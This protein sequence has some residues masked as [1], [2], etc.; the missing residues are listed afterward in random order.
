MYLVLGNLCVEAGE[1]EGESQ[2]P[3]GRRAPFGAPSLAPEITTSA[4]TQSETLTRPTQS[5]TPQS[6]V[7][8]FLP[9]WDKKSSLLIEILLS[10]QS[11]LF[12]GFQISVHLLFLRQT[13]GYTRGGS[14]SSGL[15]LAVFLG[16]LS[17]EPLAR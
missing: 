1:R 9:T 3:A 13:S 16:S 5:G 12:P 6:P 7:F 10:S 15:R 11:T 14:N 2:R 17:P 4:K 8:K